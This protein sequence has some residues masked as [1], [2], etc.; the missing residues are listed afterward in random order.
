VKI[1]Q[2]F[3]MNCPSVGPDMTNFATS[4]ATANG[5]A[6]ITQRGNA[7]QKPSDLRLICYAI[8]RCSGLRSLGS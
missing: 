3:G 2:A 7:K 4:T 8:T 6:P 1:M 5:K